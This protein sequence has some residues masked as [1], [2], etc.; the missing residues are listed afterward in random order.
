MHNNLSTTN[1]I[2]FQHKTVYDKVEFYLLCFLTFIWMSET[3]N[4]N[5]SVLSG[6]L[7]TIALNMLIQ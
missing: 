6:R 2:C 1:T 3:I 4:R 5:D 7:L